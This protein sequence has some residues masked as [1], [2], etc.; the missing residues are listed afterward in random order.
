ME[1]IVRKPEEGELEKSG[2]LGW[3]TWSCEVSTFPWTYDD[4]ETCYF[5]AGEVEV[6]AE[7]QRVKIGPG[8]I[9]VFPKGLKCTWKVTSPVRKH[10]RFG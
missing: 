6:E 3:P 9:A 4:K 8:D 10:Y 5:L 7:G 2:M 1:I